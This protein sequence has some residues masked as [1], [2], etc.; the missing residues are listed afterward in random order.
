VEFGLV[1][2]SALDNIHQAQ[3]GEGAAERQDDFC[4]SQTEK[5]KRQRMA[6]Y[7]AERKK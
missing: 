4:L 3:Q 7:A 2:I 1:S 5:M 6:A